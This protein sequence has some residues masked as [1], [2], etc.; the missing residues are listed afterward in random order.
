MMMEGNKKRV[1]A[2]ARRMIEALA[3]T[4]IPS[5]E[6]GRPGA[7]DVDLCERLLNWLAEM[8]GAT[9]AMVFVAWCWEFSPIWSGKLSRFS[10]L[11]FDDR[12]WVFEQWENSRLPARRYALFGLK[13]LFMASFYHNPE[14]WPYIGYKEGCLSPPPEPVER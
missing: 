7:T 6:P 3:D 10:R 9:F 5:G 11:S 13:A 14:I 2:G 4:I 8:P 12:T 1:S